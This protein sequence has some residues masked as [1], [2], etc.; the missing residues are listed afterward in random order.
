M[1]EE[2]EDSAQDFSSKPVPERRRLAKLRVG[3]RVF[4]SRG[5][6]LIK[7]TREG[8]VE[9]L[10]VPISSR[11]VREALEEA[12]HREPKP[13]KKRAFVQPDSEEGR[14]MGLTRPT[15]LT[16]PDSSDEGYLKEREAF[17]KRLGHTLI[18]AGLDLSIEDEEGREI[19]EPEEKIEALYG[20][21][22]TD[23]QLFKLSEDIKD[24]TRL[25]EEEEAFLA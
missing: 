21:G 6:S 17:W 4:E 7:V 13:P 11:R 5:Y 20:M 15:C 25:S 1:A 16:M 2:K 23:E 10:E 3:E 9:L 24:L 22:I 8:R 18:A 14:A 12:R 19:R